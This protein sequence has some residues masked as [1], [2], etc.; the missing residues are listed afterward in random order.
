MLTSAATALL[1]MRM[2]RVLPGLVGVRMGPAARQTPAFGCTIR[3]WSRQRDRFPSRPAHLC[4]NGCISVSGP[5]HISYE[6][7][8]LHQ[9][10][11]PLP[12][13]VRAEVFFVARVV[14]PVRNHPSMSRL[15]VIS[16][17]VFQRR[18][19][20]CPGRRMD[21]YVLP[22]VCARWI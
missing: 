9:Q 4:R 21:A 13:F 7:S 19:L 15:T 5:A 2:Q 8:V 6:T 17:V 12:G 14:R 1:V 22:L 3:G 10:A 16:Q 20:Q 18:R 11:P